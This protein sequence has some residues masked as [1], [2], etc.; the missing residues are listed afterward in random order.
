MPNPLHIN[1]AEETGALIRRLEKQLDD[2][3][4]GEIM[5]AMTREDLEQKGFI[6]AKSIQICRSSHKSG[7]E[8]EHLMLGKGIEFTRLADSDDFDALEIEALANLKRITGGQI[9]ATRGADEQIAFGPGRNVMKTVAGDIESYFAEKTGV[10]IIHKK[11]LHIFPTDIDCSIKLSIGA[12][13]MRAFM[14]LS[15]GHGSGRPLT[16]NNVKEALRQM[17]ICVGINDLALTSAIEAANGAMTRQINICAAMGAPPKEGENGRVEFTFSTEQQE[18][19]FHILPDG[20]IDYKH[21][22]NILM[23]EKDKLLA[24][25]VDPS[26]GVPGVNVL[27]EKVPAGAGR[28]AMLTAGNGVRKSQNGKE[29]YAD[30]NGSIVLNGTVIEVVN[31]YVINGDVDYSTGNVQFNGNVVINGTVPDGFEVKADGDIIVNKIVESAKLVAGRDIIIKGGVQGKGKGLV[32]A[33]RDLRVGYAQ[34]ARL[35]AEGNMYIDNF[36]INSCLFTSKCLIMQNKRGAVI[37]GEVFAQRGLDV[38][39]IGSETGVKTLID[40][41]NDYLVLRR[42]SELD[43]VIEFCK[44]NI[45]KIEESVRPFL[46]RIKAGETVA[47][48]MKGIL[49]KAVEKKKALD[50][51]LEIMLAKRSDLSEQSKDGDAAYVKVSALCYTGVM[52]KIKDFKKNVTAVRENVRFYEDKKAGEISV[53]AY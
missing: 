40:T 27:G 39:I 6:G 51:Q 22:V 2:I 21:S 52:I 17:G 20:R 1:D 8:E 31:T 14:D 43:Q 34:N 28:P 25:I 15:P 11:A 36:A 12:D 47:P 45:H 50:R 33:G 37:G 41:G 29:F 13:K 16:K 44:T 49:S 26:E 30:I 53:S 9:I 23:A 46:S 4:T 18:Y 7:T 19:D 3:E 24:R 42:L 38:K 48:A 10:A 35:E 5:C 32:C